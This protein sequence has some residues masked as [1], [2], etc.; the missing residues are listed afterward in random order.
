[1]VILRVGNI[2]YTTITTIIIIVTTTITTI[3]ITIT[4][5]TTPSL[6][7]WVEPKE[8]RDPLHFGWDIGLLL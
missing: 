2:I 7:N 4:T 6:E 1:M 3:I 5:T 8:K